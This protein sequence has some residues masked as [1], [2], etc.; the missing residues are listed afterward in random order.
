MEKLFLLPSSLIASRR[1][2]EVTTILGSCVAVCL[3]DAFLKIGGINHYMLPE[4]DGKGTPSSKFGN[5]AISQL[6]SKLENM[7]CEKKNLIA[8]IF[9]GGEVIQNNGN[10][11]NIGQR[12]IEIAEKLL[13]E[14]G[15]KIVS[16]STGGFNGRKIIF[17]TQTGEVKQKFLKKNFIN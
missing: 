13:S 14:H 1:P 12:N 15:I 9:G 2:H 6:I 8:K 5:Y 7:G 10:Q 11:F 3:Y 16:S 4:W 17:N